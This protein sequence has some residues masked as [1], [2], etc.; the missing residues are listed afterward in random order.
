MRKAYQHWCY[1][2]S[3]E[4]Q[5]RSVFLWVI[6]S[7][8]TSEAL[9]C[10]HVNSF[11]MFTGV[12]FINYTLYSNAETF[13]FKLLHKFLQLPIFSFLQFQ[14]YSMIVWHPT[15][16][17]CDAS[18]L[19]S[20][21]PKIYLWH[22][23]LDGLISQRLRKYLLHCLWNCLSWIQKVQ[24]VSQT[25]QKCL[26]L[27]LLCTRSFKRGISVPLAQPCFVLF[28]ADW[29]C[30]IVTILQVKIYVAF[31]FNRWDVI[32]MLFYD[33]FMHAI[34]VESLTQ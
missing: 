34:D 2:L 20:S 3:S 4:F 15:T 1:I 6:T 25:P 18:Q 10:T 29:H 30:L 16:C 8:Y 17:Y 7:W 22:N 12:W 26:K 31:S 14:Q 9:H 28:H 23:F 21:I 19:T 5:F 13:F 11:K 32:C 33:N 27:H 24:T